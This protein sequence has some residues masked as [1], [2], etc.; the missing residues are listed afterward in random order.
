M[1]SWGALL[2]ECAQDGFTPLYV[3]S[4]KGHEE[5]VKLLLEPADVAVNQ[6]TKVR[7]RREGSAMWGWR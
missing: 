5:V 1:L 4:Q 6:A 7:G 3:A 2:G